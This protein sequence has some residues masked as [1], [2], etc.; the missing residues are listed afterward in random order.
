[1]KKATSIDVALRPLCRATEGL[2]RLVCFHAKS[3]NYE[4]DAPQGESSK[5]GAGIWSP[6]SQWDRIP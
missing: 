4:S 3:W 6:V 1:M 2:V 5:S